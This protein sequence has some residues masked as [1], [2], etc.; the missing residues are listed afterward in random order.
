MMR[1]SQPRRKCRCCN[2]W[3]VPDPRTADRQRYCSAPACRHASKAASQH[4]WVGKH[5]NG[6]YFRGPEAVRRV[7]AW[8]ARHPGYGKPK[9]PAA[10]GTQVIAEQIATPA[11]SSCNVPRE[12]P[13]TL[14]EDCLTQAPAFVG[15]ISMVTGSTLQEDIAATARQLLLRGRNILG[16]VSSEITQRQLNLDYDQ[17]IF[18]TTATAAPHPPKL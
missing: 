10:E 17:Q 1:G 13:R 18:V 3:F 14:Q 5:G 12:L 7:Q 6:D 4:R 9:Q 11:Q 8:R 16:L 15:L 2:H